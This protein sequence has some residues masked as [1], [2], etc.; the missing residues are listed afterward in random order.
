MRHHAENLPLLVDDTGYASRSSSRVIANI[1][2]SDP[3]PALQP[4]KYL[5]LGVESPLV[6]GDWNSEFAVFL[7]RASKC[8]VIILNLQVHPLAY[9]LETCIAQQGTWE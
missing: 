5:L 2:H 3:L 1:S 4:V 6:V 7:Q 9:E 8:C